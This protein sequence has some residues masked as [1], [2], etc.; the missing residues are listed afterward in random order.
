MTLKDILVHI[1]HAEGC[2][3]RLDLA[4]ALA[5]KHSARLTGLYVVD[6]HRAGEPADTGGAATW[7]AQAV[8]SA[9]KAFRQQTDDNGISR[10]WRCEMGDAACLFGFNAR[11]ADIAIIGKAGPE[12]GGASASLADR[13]VL[14]SGRPIIVVPDGCPGSTIGERVLVAWN[15]SREAARALNDALPILEH[16]EEVAILAVNPYSDDGASD[17]MACG[18]IAEHLALHGVTVKTLRCFAPHV[19][20][21]EAIV[22]R[23]ADLNVDLVILGA[24]DQP[25]AELPALGGVARQMLKCLNVPVLLSN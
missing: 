4:V 14:S 15:A 9:E 17:D 10:L 12:D 19:D 13:V 11:N 25:R 18:E 6:S 20:V 16:A 2:R 22:S 3:E 24:R 5:T 23:A 7:T 1:D 8:A 21:G